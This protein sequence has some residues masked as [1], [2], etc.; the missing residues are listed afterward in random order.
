MQTTS[1][2]LWASAKTLERRLSQEAGS[3]QAKTEALAKLEAEGLAD[4]RLAV[5]R[6]ELEYSFDEE[7]RQRLTKEIESL[8]KKTEAL[9]KLEAE[10][11]ADDR[12]AVARVE[13]EY[14]FD[15]EER[16]RLTEEIESLEVRAGALID[17]ALWPNRNER[18]QYATKLEQTKNP[19]I[20]RLFAQYFEC[21]ESAEQTLRDGL[22]IEQYVEALDRAGNLLMLELGGAGLLRRK[23]LSTEPRTNASNDQI[24]RAFAGDYL[25]LLHIS[26]RRMLYQWLAAEDSSG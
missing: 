10:G 2:R 22:D 7:E 3:A 18:E 14:S 1:A 12:L 5:A 23:G 6:V 24:E 8:E 17:D 15:E 13:L 4:D 9:A 20:L 21:I 16:Q 25:D 26:T 19:S 11:L